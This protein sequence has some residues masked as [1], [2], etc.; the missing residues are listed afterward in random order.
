MPHGHS[1]RSVEARRDKRSSARFGTVILRCAGRQPPRSKQT[2]RRRLSKHRRKSNTGTNGA[3]TMNDAR[4][5]FAT[6]AAKEPVPLARGAL[7]I[8][9][10]EY[11]NLDID[12]YLDK[13]ATLSRQ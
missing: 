12:E 7:L 13:I 5:E 2:E 3:P 11:P 1:A 4:R 10:E 9:K 6:I 8:A